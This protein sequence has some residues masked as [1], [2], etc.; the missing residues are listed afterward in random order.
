MTDTPISGAT[1]GEPVQATVNKR[2]QQ[3]IAIREALKQMEEKHEAEKKDLLEAKN[4]VAGWLQSFMENAGC[5]SIK[6]EHGTCH[7]TTRTTASVADPALFMAFVIDNKQFDLLD[8]RANSTA[9]KEY[10]KEHGAQPP[11]VNLSSIKTVGVRRPGAK[12]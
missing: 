11:G 5:E 9:V 1:A 6:T 3:F 2:V 4:L 7:F 10:V 12:D 8:R